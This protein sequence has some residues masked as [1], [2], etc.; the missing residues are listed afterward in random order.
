MDKKIKLLFRMNV[1]FYVSILL[2][3]FL[4]KNGNFDNFN[5]IAKFI[6]GSIPLLLIALTSFVLAY[7]ANQN[8]ICIKNISKIDFIIRFFS[9]IVTLYEVNSLNHNWYLCIIAILFI[10]NC[11][12]EYKMNI[13]LSNS[14]QNKE[15]IQIPYEEKCNLNNMVKSSNLAIFSWLIFCMVCLNISNLKNME[16]S[17]SSGIIPVIVSVLVARWFIKINY[18]NYI[19]FYLDKVYAKKIFK[20]DLIFAIVGYIICLI[21]SFIKFNYTN[22]LI[23][24]GI[25]F[26]IPMINTIRKMSLRLYKIKTSLGKEEY[27]NFIVRDENI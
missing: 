16:G 15:N 17:E 26:S 10:L 8:L 20:R 13:K 18:K 24:L 22:Y 3:Y 25:I 9:Y 23:I 27:Y 21:G 5:N 4:L 12:I 2:I 19:R 7:D 14:E 1:I 11:I 6:L